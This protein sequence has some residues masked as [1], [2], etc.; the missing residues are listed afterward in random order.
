MAG[1]RRGVGVKLTAAIIAKDEADRIGPCL[2]SLAFADEIVVLDSGS[3]DDTVAVCRAHGARV[4]E[5]DWPGWVKQKRRAVE[6][7]SN[8]W[9]LSLDADERVDD[10]LCA[11]ILDL[12][13]ARPGE[14]ADGPAAYEM[15]RQTRYL[16][17]WIRHGGWFPE[18]RVRLFDRRRARWGGVDPHDRVEVS[19]P[20]ERIRHG[21]ILHHSF[22]SL[23]D[24]VRQVNR[25]TSVS[26]DE[27][28]ARGR[29][30]G[31]LSML[32][33]PPYHAFRMYVLRLG[34]LDGWPGFVAAGMN[35]WYVFLKYAKAWE[36]GR[37]GAR[38]S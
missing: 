12:A 19:G 36:R 28:L 38:A 31:V 18:W 16:G 21:K 35:G 23:A 33:R 29:R 37:A 24:H 9:V 30:P 22:R 1:R 6:A 7:A 34:F 3:A 8:D 13:R 26:A 32:V 20:V 17:R 5:T 25:F 11:V 10:E 27:M 4:I 14:A 2:E 15:T